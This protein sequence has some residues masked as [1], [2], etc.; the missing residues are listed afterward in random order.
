MQ[1]SRWIF[2]TLVL[3]VALNVALLGIFFYFLIRDNPLHFSYRP[4]EAVKSEHPPVPPG[5]LARL[6]AVSFDHLVELLSDVRK[7]EQ[8]FRVQEVAL[9]ALAA[10]HDFDVERGLGRGKLSKHVWEYEGGRFF[11]FPGLSE[12]DFET[13]KTFAAVEQWPLTSQGLFKKIRETG[14]ENCDPALIGFFC[15]TPEFVLFETLFARTHLP[16]Q[17]RS[18]LNLALEGGWEKFAVF[19]AG[20]EAGID[21]SDECRQRVLLGAI[22]EGSK[23]AAYLLLITDAPFATQQLDDIHLAR[24]LDLLTAKTQESGQFVQTIASSSRI[25]AIREKAMARISEYTGNSPGEVASHFYEKP[26]QKELRPVFREAP[27]AAPAPGSHVVQ[28]GESLWIIA[29]KY[30]VSIDA[31]MEANQMQNSVIR[32]GKTLKI[33]R[34]A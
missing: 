28:D 9:G 5:F 13:L 14:L 1:N 21:F 31:L 2:Q 26:G 27:P 4:K 22:D 7:M 33:P 23:T 30:K 16:I 12:T 18:V 15:H 3:S 29:R 17:K 10:Y 20:Q 6:P 8:G 34:P 25:N 32:P 19:T 24:V 11:L